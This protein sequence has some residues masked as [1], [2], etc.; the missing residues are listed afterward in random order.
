MLTSN[1]EKTC[2]TINNSRLTK[3]KNRLSIVK[4]Y[5]FLLS[6]NSIIFFDEDSFNNENELSHFFVLNKSNIITTND[7]IVFNSAKILGTRIFFTKNISDENN[8]LRLMK[9]KFLI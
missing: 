2:L 4:H 9:V 1:L 7:Y 5:S 6:E 3:T 8:S